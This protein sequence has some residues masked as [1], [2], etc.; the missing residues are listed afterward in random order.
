MEL[1]RCEAKLSSRSISGQITH[2]MRIERSPE[3]SY[4][5]IRSTLEGRKCPD[6]LTGVEQEVLVEQLLELAG[7][8]T[9]E[10]K[11]FFSILQKKDLGVEIDKGGQIAV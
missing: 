11:E 5:N 1:V 10:Q 2:W 9:P 3:F 7:K 6:T 4:A 8:P